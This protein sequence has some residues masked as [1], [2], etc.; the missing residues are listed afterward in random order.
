MAVDAFRIVDFFLEECFYC[1]YKDRLAGWLS[2]AILQ[3]ARYI[4]TVDVY[5]QS[6][7]K[8]TRT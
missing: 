1:Y 7:F 3:I 4:T 6:V 8:S 5:E 2:S